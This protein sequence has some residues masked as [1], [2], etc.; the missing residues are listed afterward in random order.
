MKPGKIKCV[1]ALLSAASCFEFQASGANKTPHHRSSLLAEMK[2]W[3]ST[4]RRDEDLQVTVRKG[5]PRLSI[6]R[7]AL[8]YLI[9]NGPIPDSANPR[10]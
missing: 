2:R 4:V 6:S 7:P 3:L 1:S 9:P 8:T 10:L 5:E